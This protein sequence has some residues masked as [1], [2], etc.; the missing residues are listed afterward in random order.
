MS[1]FTRSATYWCV[2]ELP[3]LQKQLIIVIKCAALTVQ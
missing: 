1:S 3:F 2:V